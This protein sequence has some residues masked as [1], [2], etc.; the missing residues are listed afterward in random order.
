MTTGEEALE[1]FREANLTD[2]EIHELIGRLTVLAP[3]T[4][5]KAIEHVKEDRK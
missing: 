1:I 2:L 3:N 4:L 5:V